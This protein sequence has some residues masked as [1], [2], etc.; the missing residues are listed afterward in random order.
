MPEPDEKTEQATFLNDQRLQ[1][2]KS[3][4]E[5]LALYLS[6]G[7]K[8]S[9]AVKA[10]DAKSIIL[11]SDVPGD[12]CVERIHVST[13]QRNVPPKKGPPPPRN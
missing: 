8:L 6:N 11:S 7:V 1:V 9:G 3:S 5:I 13:F 4:G 12:V 2:A 10:F